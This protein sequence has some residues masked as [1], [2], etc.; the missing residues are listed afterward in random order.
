MN[1]PFDRAPNPDRSA[2]AQLGAFVRARLAADPSVHRIPTDRAEI[3]GVTG[4]L[5]PAECLQMVAM[6]DRT[7]QPSRVFDHG[8]A[9][10][11]RTSYSGDVERHDPFVR[12]IERRIDDLLGIPHAFGETI[13]GQRY[14]P[15]QQFREHNDW[16]YTKMPYWKQEKRNGGQRCFTAMV[17]LNTVEEGGTTDFTRI[18][19]SI[20]PQQGALIIWNNATVKGDVNVDTL[21]AGTPVI[22][23]VKYIITKWYRTRKWG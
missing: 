2:L 22:R 23:G 18:G 8:Y 11:Y 7:A 21:H 5:N 15:G 9:A 17:Y 13:Q 4:F 14:L 1:T 19:L 10:N 3:W 16:F 12:M 20:P 6:I